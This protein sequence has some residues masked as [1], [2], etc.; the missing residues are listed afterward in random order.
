ME[1]QIRFCT[2]SDG[3][4]IAYATV[5]EGP[6]L[7]VVPGWVSHLEVLWEWPDRRR[8]LEALAEHFFVVSYD[9][10]GTGLSDRGVGD[11]STAARVRDLEAVVD[12][13]KLHRTALYGLSEGGAVA[14]AYAA[15]HPRVVSRMILY[16]THA[17]MV[18]TPEQR[19]TIDALEAHVRAEWGLGSRTLAN[20]F[21]PG[22]TAEDVSRFVKLQ[23]KGATRED[24]ADMLRANVEADVFDL[25][26]QVS[27]PTLVIHVTG[28]LVVP[29]ERGREIAG[30]IPNARLVAIEGDRHSV[31]SKGGAQ[32]QE[33]SLD[34]LLEDRGPQ[35]K[36]SMVAAP[37]GLVTILFTDMEGST[38]LTQRLGDARLK[39]FSACTMP[40]CARR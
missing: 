39:N 24:A 29:F 31:G 11:Y 40:S 23:E 33:A 5:G 26:P 8:F 38:A 12:S 36:E 3:V 4:S 27:A 10:R 17:R 25:L 37:P 18:P 30:H 35:A 22:A 6:P 13:L 15:R 34:F 19:E 1:P 20:L 16:G 9:K 21:M 32:I 28:D 14:I 2:T 7:V